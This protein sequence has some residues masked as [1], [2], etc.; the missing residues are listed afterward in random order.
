MKESL[1]RKYYNLIQNLMS[2]YYH[3]IPNIKADMLSRLATV[4]K[5]GLHRSVLY[6]N[7]RNPSVSTDECMAIDEKANWMTPIKQFIKNGECGVQEERTKRQQI[8]QF[9]LIG[10]NL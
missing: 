8:T 5:K 6:I 2:K 1:L 10:S 3:L 4:K 9:I 7:I